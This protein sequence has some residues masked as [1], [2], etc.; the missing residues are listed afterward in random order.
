MLGTRYF[1]RWALISRCSCSA[2]HEE[3]ALA[4]TERKQGPWLHGFTCTSAPDVTRSK[5]LERR[6]L[7]VMCHGAGKGGENY[8]PFGGRRIFKTA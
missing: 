5:N 4:R 7:T 2:Y 1:A 6:V 8:H 3:Y